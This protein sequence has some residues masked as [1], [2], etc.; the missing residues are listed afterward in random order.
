[1]SSCPCLHPRAAGFE[2]TVEAAEI[3]A[4]PAPVHRGPYPKAEARDCSRSY[5]KNLAADSDS[6]AAAESLAPVA[7]VSVAAVGEIASAEVAA[8]GVA[9][10]GV[11][12]EPAAG[13]AAGHPAASEM[14]ETAVAEAVEAAF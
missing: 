11:G 3:A 14:T 4:A 9:A 1:M 10:A 12:I 7:G 13:A 5:P 2:A 6:A 8:A